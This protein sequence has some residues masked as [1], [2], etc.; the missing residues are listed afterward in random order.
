MHAA[1][2]R[3]QQIVM[4]GVNPCLEILPAPFGI[5]MRR[6]SHRQRV[7]AI[8]G[9]QDVRSI[10]AILAAG[11]RHDAIIAA[12]GA[13]MLIKHLAQ[14]PFAIFPIYGVVLLL[15]EAASVAD[16]LLV[17]MDRLFLAIFCVRVFNR[18]VRTLIGNHTTLAEHDF[19]QD[20]SQ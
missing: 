4:S 5:N 13:A 3:H 17:E 10:K 18:R 11:P 1:I 9:S 6:P 2:R 20:S 14:L 16:A 7:H 8:F 19:P 15:S 12:I